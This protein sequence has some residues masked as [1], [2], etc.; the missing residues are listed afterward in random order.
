MLVEIKMIL[1]LKIL[2]ASENIQTFPGFPCLLSYNIVSTTF[3][4]KF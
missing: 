2:G 1:L 3:K 4:K